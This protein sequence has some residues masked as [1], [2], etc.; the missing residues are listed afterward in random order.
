MLEVKGQTKKRWYYDAL[1]TLVIR[2]WTTLARK[3]SKKRTAKGR[4]MARK[5]E[6]KVALCSDAAAQIRGIALPIDGGWTAQ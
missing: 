3:R 6:G 4:I 1:L 5:F 2:L